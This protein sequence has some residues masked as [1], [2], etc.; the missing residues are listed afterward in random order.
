MSP[1]STSEARSPRTCC[2]R[3]PT[4]PESFDRVIVATTSSLAPSARDA[5]GEYAEVLERAN[6]GQ[7]FGSWHDGL[8]R[9]DFAADFD[10]LLLDE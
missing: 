8:L 2:G 5:L 10:E 7:D 3:W 9:S 6:V 4:S 1:T